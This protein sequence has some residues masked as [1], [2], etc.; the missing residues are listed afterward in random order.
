AACTLE[1]VRTGTFGNIVPGQTCVLV[2]Y[3]LSYPNNAS[4]DVSTNNLAASL[5]GGS[6]EGDDA[7]GSF[8]NTYHCQR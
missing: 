2:P 7:T 4:I 3:T 8:S 5:G 6:F 1:F